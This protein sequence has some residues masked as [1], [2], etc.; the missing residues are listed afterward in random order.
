MIAGMATHVVR[1][2]AANKCPCMS[3]Y[4]D[5]GQGTMPPVYATPENVGRILG[6]DPSQMTV[7]HRKEAQ[8]Q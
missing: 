6:T 3:I 5:L 2:M 4:L 7:Q 1:Q 8:E